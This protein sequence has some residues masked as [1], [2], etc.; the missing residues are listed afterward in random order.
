MEQSRQQSEWE[1]NPLHLA[2]CAIEANLEVQ[3]CGSSTS[4]CFLQKSCN[5][6]GSL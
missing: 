6:R 1:V 5:C 4:L 2:K 3:S